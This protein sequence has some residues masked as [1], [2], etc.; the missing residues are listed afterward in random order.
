MVFFNRALGLAR[1][2]LPISTADLDG[3]PAE[4]G[5]AYVGAVRTLVRFASARPL[6]ADLLLFA[7]V[8]VA[9]SAGSLISYSWFG[10]L[11]SPTFFP[12]AGV[13]VGALVLVSGLRRRA[14][15]LAA[16][17][18]AEICVNIF[19]GGLDVA[20]SAGYAVANLSEASLAAFLIV[21]IARGAPL[22][23]R[24][25]IA[26]LVTGVLVAPWLGG[27]IAAGVTALDGG[28]VTA[29]SYLG[30]WWLGDAL[31]I[32]LVGGGLIA[33]A[34]EERRHGRFYAGLAAFVLVS[35]LAAGAALWWD[36]WP[37]GY[38]PF[39]LTLVAAWR[40]GALGALATALVGAT[41]VAQ[42]AASAQ[43]LFDTT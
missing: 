10:A 12:S 30:H 8:G 1:G 24:R 29:A 35:A 33:A 28:H 22:V 16:A 7:V 5:A 38:V 37:A 20:P 15:V 18:T 34:T 25:G 26:G 11:V 27:S 41:V 36:V 13:T 32:L 21:A 3:T 4:R 9:Y 23:E 40:V 43:S 31:G 17:A 14:I 39:V 6:A 2:V 42:A 19:H